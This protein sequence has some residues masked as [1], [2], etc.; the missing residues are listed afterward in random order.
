MPPSD[1]YRGRMFYVA[2]FR[3]CV[4]SK[5]SF[6]FV[7]KWA[8]INKTKLSAHLLMM[9]GRKQSLVR[10][11][12]HSLFPYCSCLHH[13]AKI[14]CHHR[15]CMLVLPEAALCPASFSVALFLEGICKQK[16]DLMLRELYGTSAPF[17]RR[18][19]T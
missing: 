11:R 7:V 15:V 8:T 2:N 12:V 13:F 5:H 3:T 14:L 6:G 19:W 17:R 10:A 18:R 9:A 16:N 1:L 4:Y